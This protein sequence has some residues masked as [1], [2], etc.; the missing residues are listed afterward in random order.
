MASGNGKWLMAMASGSGQ[1]A[2]ANANGNGKW[3]IAMANG[4]SKWQDMRG[5]CSTCCS[6][7][8]G[9]RKANGG[10]SGTCEV[11]CQ[12]H[13]TNTV[14]NVALVHL[15]TCQPTTA[16]ITPG[17]GVLGETARVWRFEDTQ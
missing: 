7:V 1:M 3:H 17:F 5:E 6:R 13:V 10:E 2:M 4:S 16:V 12:Q 8:A 11:V 9:G 14:V 15:G